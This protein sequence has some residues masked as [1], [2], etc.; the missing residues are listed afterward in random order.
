MF[1]WALWSFSVRFTAKRC[2]E[3][4]NKGSPSKIYETDSQDNK[5][6][7]IAAAKRSADPK[8]L[9]HLRPNFT[10]FAAIELTVVF[11]Q[12]YPSV[13]TFL[14]QVAVVSSICILLIL[15]IVVVCFLSLDT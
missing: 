6:F 9:Q 12:Y 14:Q 13:M 7:E 5:T 3:V 11:L 8:L 1:R 10:Y 4:D 2:G 15:M